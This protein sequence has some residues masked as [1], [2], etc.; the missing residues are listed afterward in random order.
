MITADIYHHQ[1]GSD[2]KKKKRASTCG[3]AKANDGQNCRVVRGK[4]NSGACYNMGGG[5]FV[6]I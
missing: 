2:K 3:K 5:R 1:S 6:L 4:E